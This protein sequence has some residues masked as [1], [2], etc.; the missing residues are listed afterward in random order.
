MTLNQNYPMVE[1]I[2]AF[3]AAIIALI[4]IQVNLELEDDLHSPEWFQ[5]LV[6][7]SLKGFQY[8]SCIFIIGYFFY[9]LLLEL[10]I[11]S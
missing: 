3:M 9:L 11:I 7:M 4:F 10:K 5:N 8:A 6:L 2:H 1:V